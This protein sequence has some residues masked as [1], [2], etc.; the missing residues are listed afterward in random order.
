VLFDKI[1]NI[2]CGKKTYGRESRGKIL[3][4]LLTIN[5]SQKYEYNVEFSLNMPTDIE[6]NLL[7]DFFRKI[8]ANLFMNIINKSVQF[9]EE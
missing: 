5:Y 1:L 6:V 7:Y 4:R 9:E 2:K 8:F 3:D